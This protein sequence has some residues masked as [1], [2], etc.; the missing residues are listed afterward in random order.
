MM[1]GT[2]AM[3][4][5][6]PLTSPRTAPTPTAKAI[7]A[8]LADPHCRQAVGRQVRGDAEGGADREV[9]VAGDDHEGFAGGEREVIEMA[10]SSRLTKRELR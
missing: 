1:D 10:I 2:L 4:T 3:A 9:D 5:S 8:R 7:A 6:K